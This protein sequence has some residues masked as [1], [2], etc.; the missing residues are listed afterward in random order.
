MSDSRQA[1]LTARAPKGETRRGGR[2][3]AR[4]GK[5]VWLMFLAATAFLIVGFVGFAAQVASQSNQTAQVG[6]ADGIVVLTGG[7]ARLDA[8][9]ALLRDGRGARLLI[10]GVHTEISEETLRQTLGVSEELYAC[11]VDID[12]DALDTAGNAQGSADWAALNGYTSL[13]VVT[14]DY[15]VPRAMLEMR[16]VMSDHKLTAYPV[17]NEKPPATDLP[18]TIDR[19]RVLV[20]EYAKFLV[21]QAR[22]LSI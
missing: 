14:N 5:L 1:D 21:A 9:V 11:C 13:I 4:L 12:R 20:G 22:G 7:R 19:Y 3:G 15:H 6:S 2:T 10:S 17:I 18:Q 16:R 8:A